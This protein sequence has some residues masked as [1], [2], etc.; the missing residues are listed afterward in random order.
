MFFLYLLIRKDLSVRA[1]LFWLFLA[2]L[3]ILRHIIHLSVS[4]TAGFPNHVAVH[5]AYTILW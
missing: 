5:P 2:G 3:L 4:S 1:G